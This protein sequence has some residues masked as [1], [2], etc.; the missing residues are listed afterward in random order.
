LVKPSGPGDL[1]FFIPFKETKISSIVTGLSPTSF[2]FRKETKQGKKKNISEIKTGDVTYTQ[3]DDI[4]IQ[5]V[6]FYTDLFTSDYLSGLAVHSTCSSLNCL[7][8]LVF[9]L[10]YP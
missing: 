8:E 6:E 5:F 9:V 4:I 3:N 2:F 1:L 7:Y 10:F